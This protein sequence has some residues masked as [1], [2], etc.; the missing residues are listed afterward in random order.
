MDR[1]RNPQ[2]GIFAEGDR[3]HGFVEFDVRAANSDGTPDLAALGGALAGLVTGAGADPWHA[4]VAVGS[5]LARD[6]FGDDVP[7]GLRD[8]VAIEGEG[9]RRAPATQHEILIWVHGGDSDVVFDAMRNAVGAL[10]GLA[11]VVGETAGFVY[12]D[13]RDLSGFIDGTENPDGDEARTVAVVGGGPGQGGS[14]V[15]T[16][17][18]VHDFAAIESMPVPDQERVIG[19]TKPDSIELD[20]LPPD[21][22]VARMVVEDDSGEEMEIYRR[23]VPYG[24]TSEAGLY[25][26]AFTDDLDKV[27]IMLRRMYGLIDGPS[28]RLLEWTRPVSGSY[29]YAPS[30]GQF[31]AIGSS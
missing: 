19:R 13:S 9:G 24:S 10:E 29:W 12:H 2:P 3:H 11:S 7:P 6:L 28:D 15:F 14:L 17:R 25:F 22:H 23:S 8:F 20:P 26:L 27:D 1:V 21:S 16:Q 31:G 18:W 30:P 4:V 5:K